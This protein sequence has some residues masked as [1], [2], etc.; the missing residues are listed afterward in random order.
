VQPVTAYDISA[1]AIRRELARGAAGLE[2]VRSLLPPP[3]LAYIERNQLYRP[4]PC[5]QGSS[6]RSP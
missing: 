2:A 3:V 4:T 1:T 6:P 5:P